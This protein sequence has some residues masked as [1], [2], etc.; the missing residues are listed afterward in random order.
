MSDKAIKKLAKQIIEDPEY[1]DALKVRIANGDATHIETMLYHYLYGKPAQQLV[2]EAGTT[3]SDLV[4][5][6]REQATKNIVE[7]DLV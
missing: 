3:L 5:A 2:I 1:Q 4:L 7:G 6:S